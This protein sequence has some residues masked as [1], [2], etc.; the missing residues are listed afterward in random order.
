MSSKKQPERRT[1]LQDRFDILI[2][3]QKSGKAT[4]SEL[5]ELDEI[6]NGDPSNAEMKNNLGAIYLS[7]Q[8]L[9]LAIAQFQKAI[10]IDPNYAVAYGNLGY[11]YF[12]AVQYREAIESFKKELSLTPKSNSDISY[13]ATCYRKL[14]EPDS[15]KKYEAMITK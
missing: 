14:N 10:N 8:K 15:A 13:I 4:F 1:F 11:A 9:S 2:K 6:V 7:E 12:L 5:T 3:R